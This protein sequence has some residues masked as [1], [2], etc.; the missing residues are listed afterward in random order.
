MN[1]NLN[2]AKE[3]ISKRFLEKTEDELIKEDADILMANYLSEIERLRELIGFNQQDL[4]L[5]IKLTPSYLSQVFTGK[6]PL[7]FITLAKIKRVLKIKF[8]VTARLEQE[9]IWSIQLAQS[10]TSNVA[11]SVKIKNESSQRPE[12]YFISGAK[13]YDAQQTSN[14]S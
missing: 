3:K 1:T 6:K 5:R 4:A 11:R 14:A 9:G 2:N 12:L 13:Y 7:N 8:S 10:D